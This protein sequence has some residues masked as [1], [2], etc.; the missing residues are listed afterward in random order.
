[1]A[2]T[3]THADQH[4][5]ILR[6]CDRSMTRMLGADA[7]LPIRDGGSDPDNRRPDH[8]TRAEPPKLACHRDRT[9]PRSQ[10]L[11][12]SSQDCMS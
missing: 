9:S 6:A 4:G 10:R 8:P 2:R 12:S 5:N 11:H 3:P 1:M 7:R